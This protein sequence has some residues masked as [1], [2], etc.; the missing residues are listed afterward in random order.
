MGSMVFQGKVEGR[1]ILK[2]IQL[3]KILGQYTGIV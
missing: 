3:R 1:C 2:E